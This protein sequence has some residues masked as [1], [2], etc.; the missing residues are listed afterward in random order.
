MTAMPGLRR[1]KPLERAP[2]CDPHRSQATM[3]PFWEQAAKRT[4]GCGRR[5]RVSSLAPLASE[6]SGA[7]TAPQKCLHSPRL[8]AGGST[9]PVPGRA[10]HND[11]QTSACGRGRA[12]AF[13]LAFPL[14]PALLNFRAQ[15]PIADIREGPERIF[16]GASLRGGPLSL[17][18][19]LG[20]TADNSSRLMIRWQAGLAHRC[21]AAAGSPRPGPRAG[22][23]RG[24]SPRC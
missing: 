7:N 20:G 2:G 14:P 1:D 13:S 5:D 4:E 24:S 22:S 17:S 23:V 15:G 21:R 10:A 3:F 8:G 19:Q 12:A 16:A 11:G 18:R 9:P 6:R